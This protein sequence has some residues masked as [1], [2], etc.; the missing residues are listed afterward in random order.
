VD[1]DLRTTSLRREVASPCIGACRLDVEH[2]CVG[3]G[4]RMH[5]I[6]AWRDASDE[7]R[8]QIRAAAAARLPRPAGR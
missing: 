4:R 7:R 1:P 3:C 6:V 8:L 5:E 2:V